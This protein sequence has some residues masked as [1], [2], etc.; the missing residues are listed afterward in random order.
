MTEALLY[1]NYQDAEN[2]IPATHSGLSGAEAFLSSGYNF[3]ILGSEQMWAVLQIHVI[4]ICLELLSIPRTPQQCVDLPGVETRLV[5]LLSG[6][7]EFSG[8]DTHTL[9]PIGKGRAGC[10]GAF[11]LTHW[12]GRLYSDPR[13]RLW[14]GFSVAA[15]AGWVGPRLFS[16]PLLWRC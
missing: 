4:P 5:C 15:V 1:T 2:K 14:N 9:T 11:H 3:I 6:L 12:A 13:R 8:A 16:W 10:R 7:T